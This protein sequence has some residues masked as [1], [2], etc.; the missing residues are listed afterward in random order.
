MH[1]IRITA[2]SPG[3][4][5]SIGYGSGNSKPC[6]RPPAV[7]ASPR[8]LGE[9][10]RRRQ[11]FFKLFWIDKRTGKGTHTLDARNDSDGSIGMNKSLRSKPLPRLAPDEVNTFRR[12]ARLNTEYLWNNSHLSKYLAQIIAEGGILQGKRIENRPLTKRSKSHSDREATRH[13]ASPFPCRKTKG[14]RRRCRSIL[15]WRS[16]AKLTQSASHCQTDIAYVGEAAIKT[17]FLPSTSHPIQECSLLRLHL[18]R[19]HKDQ[20]ILALPNRLVELVLGWRETAGA[21]ISIAGTKQ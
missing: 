12:N 1:L 20:H 3:F 18:D 17:P 4:V 7:D 16:S 8:S 14:P 5:L 21:P 13:T 6:D 11:C 19:L 10:R 9:E 2:S 15:S